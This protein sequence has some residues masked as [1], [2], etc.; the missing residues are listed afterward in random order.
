MEAPASLANIRSG[1]KSLAGTNALAFLASSSVMEKKSLLL[2]LTPGLP[3]GSRRQTCR[4][5][6]FEAIKTEKRNEDGQV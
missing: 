2:T 3:S 5:P 6:G 1:L 4:L